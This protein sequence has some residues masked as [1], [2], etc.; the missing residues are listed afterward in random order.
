MTALELRKDAD[1]TRT[2]ILSESLLDRSDQGCGG[3]LHCHFLLGR[4]LEGP[5]AEVVEIW[6]GVISGLL[7]RARLGGETPM[8]ITPWRRIAASW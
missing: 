3:F 5:V 6:G 4:G 2:G 1:G 8:E 7:K